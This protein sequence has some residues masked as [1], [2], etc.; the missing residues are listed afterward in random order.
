VVAVGRAIATSAPEEGW[1]VGNSSA[2]TIE[3][4]LEKA[5]TELNRIRSGILAVERRFASRYRDVPEAQRASATNLLHYLALRHE[6]LRPLQAELMA[7][8]LSSLGRAEAG[9]LASVQTVLDVVRRLA[10]GIDRPTSEVAQPVPP[11]GLAEGRAILDAHARALLGAPPAARDVR[12]MVTMPSEAADDYG[13]VRDLLNTGM[14]CMRINTVH[15]DARAWDRMLRHLERAKQETGRSC[16]VLMDLGGPKPR[17]GAIQPGPRVVRWKPR[18]DAQG[19]VIDPARIWLTSRER[20]QAAPQSAAA[21]LFVDDAWLASLE[22]G[23]TVKLKDARGSKRTLR[24]VARTD[25]AVWAES[26]QTAYVMPNTTLRLV[27]K[28]SDVRR[29]RRSRVGDLPAFPQSIVLAP[30]DRLLLSRR[31]PVGS[32]AV[33]GACG[34]VLQPAIIGV[35]L[36]DVLS[37]VRPGEA[38]WFDDGK[39]GGVIE[40]MTD[41]RITVK[42]T[43]AAPAGS[44]LAG[45]KGINLPDSTLRQPALTNKD[46]EDLPFIAARADLVG[47]S[48]VQSESDVYELQSR[49]AAFGRPLGVILK[50]ETRQAFEHLPELLLAAMRSPAAG[51]M[52]ARGDLAVECGYERLAEVQEE[53]L[54]MAEASH[55][56]VIWATQVMENLAKKGVPSRAEVTDA[57]MGERA[58]CVLLNKGPYIL[59][60]VRALD[61]ILTRM[62]AH[63]KKKST[64]LRHLSL[65][66]R[67]LDAEPPAG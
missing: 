54:W 58:E 40:E 59:D 62:Q 32:P 31:H 22:I 35:T 23:D 7:L 38:I 34:E 13:L 57:A 53:I 3:S 67:F 17:T 8:G 27:R 37:D 47:Y 28:G 56:P 43:Q 65:A 66:D 15:D 44:K 6:D 46:L 21:S 39:I 16:C 61:G 29:N 49:L 18:R 24:I 4:T 11:V 52:V 36:P 55:M 19:H 5:G 25:A 42:I 48:F 64:M 14:D 10:R 41:D 9:V 50:I 2:G 60:A 51:V 63:Q 30:G 26:K 33:V 1:L 20:P 12:I 45:G